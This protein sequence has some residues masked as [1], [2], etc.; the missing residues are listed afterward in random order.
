MNCATEDGIANNAKWCTGVAGANT[1]TAIVIWNDGE[2]ISSHE[3]ISVG[4]TSTKADGAGNLEVF[5]WIGS[6]DTDKATVGI[7][8]KIDGRGA[9]GGLDGAIGTEGGA[10]WTDVD[11]AGV[12]D[13]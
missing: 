3:N 7:K 12:V 13:H 10:N 4:G 8:G 11:E 2:I 6:T 5:T 9:D 1:D